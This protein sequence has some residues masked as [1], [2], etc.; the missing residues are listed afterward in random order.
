MKARPDI[1]SAGNAK[2]TLTNN[3]FRMKNFVLQLALA[4]S[5]LAGGGSTAWAA[6]TRQMAEETR[7]TVS[8]K[9]IDAKRKTPLV[10][11]NVTVEGTST[12]VTTGMDGIYRIQLT[13][14]QSLRFSYLGYADHVAKISGAV[15]HLDVQLEESSTSLDDVVVVAYGTQRKGDVLSSISTTGSKELMRAPVSTTSGALIGKIAGVN[16]RNTEGT[17]G[18]SANIQI[19]N[20]G[21][22]LYVI[23]GVVSDA[24]HFNQLG[25]TDIESIS[26]IKDG[27]AAIYGV[28][29]ANGVVLVQTKRGKNT[30]GRISVGVNA[31][32]GWQSWNRFPEMGNAYEVTRAEYEGQINSG[33]AVDVAAAKERLQKYKEGYYNP[34]TGEDYRSFDWTSF[35]RKNVPQSYFNIYSSGGGDRVNYYVSISKVDQDAV[36]KDF[37]F[38]RANFQANVSANI[39][40]NLSISMASSGRKE[41]RKNPGL[42]SDDDYMYMRWGMIANDPRYRPY[43]NDNPK[44]PA[45]NDYGNGLFNLGA[46]DISN[47]GF[48]E[49]IWRVFQ[50]TWDIQWK[51]P[52]EGLTVKGLYSYYY[53]TKE[54]TA[55]QKAYDFYSYD[56]ATDTYNVVKR[57]EDSWMQRGEDGIEE[58]TY[59]F[60]LNYDRTFAEDHHVTVLAGF[61]AQNR[62]AQ[63]L[64]VAQNPVENNFIP[65]LT[66]NRDLIAYL[67]DGF[68]EWATAGF[69]VRGSYAYKDRYL[70]EFAGRYDGSWRF[71]KENRWSFFPSVSA[72]WRISEEPFFKESSVSNWFSNLKIR[73]SYGEMGDDNVPGYGDFD[74]LGGYTFNNGSAIISKDPAGALEGSFIKG[75][76]ARQTPVTTVSWITA[77]MINLGIDAGFFNNKLTVEFDMFQRRRSG[78]L[79]DSELIL[80]AEV[81]VRIPKKNLNTDMT[82]GLDATVRWNDETRGGFRYYAGFNMSLARLKNVFVANERTNNSWD[83]YLWSSNNRWANASGRGSAW[84]YQVVGQFKTQEQ[85]DN[86]PVDIDGQGNRTLLP[87]DYYYKDW[88]NDGKINDYDLRPLG[89]GSDLPYLNF[90][91]NIGFEWRGIDFAADFAG[92]SMQTYVFTTDARYPF[93]DQN[94]NAPKYMLNDRW[95]HEDIF[96]PTSPWVPGTYPAIRSNK[97]DYETGSFK[98][99]SSFLLNNTNYLRL[100]NLE[101]GYSLPGRWLSKVK[102]EKLR[103]Y[104]NGSNLFS[105]DNLHDKGLDPEQG[106]SS[107]LNYPIHRVYTIGANLVF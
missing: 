39:T 5:L 88:N 31:Y 19:R 66:D 91:I 7:I 62:K 54:R 55:F 106:V 75:S 23:D 2:P 34:E 38:N 107:G 41:V 57:M 42:E 96:D 56:Y 6:G 37:N 85:I 22:P 30:G 50:G 64:L 97:K 70:V 52:L 32:Y 63:S 69:M 76:A 101:I 100:K 79:A 99:Q 44:Y 46:K 74:Y 13:P 48:Y 27:A 90:G 84:L 12:G 3:L 18:S 104:V 29:A 24:G 102:I 26:V 73:F 33:V 20:L 89:Y 93:W 9:V 43:A 86:H 51:T 1:L 72:G 95:H 40:D 61:E 87:G 35:A 53:A 17:P 105:I 59:Q 36:F 65:I 77:K 103:I 80:P 16:S 78:L 45:Y 92:A 58:N 68:Y 8:G 25:L 15:S 28:K 83:R 67:T 81:S 49:D 82:T 14:G 10:G 47:A 71:P 98:D 21:T 11:V 60:T 94:R 4:L